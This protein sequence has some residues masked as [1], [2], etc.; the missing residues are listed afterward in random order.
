M[1]MTIFFISCLLASRAVISVARNIAQR[2]QARH[3]EICAAAHGDELRNATQA[4]RHSVF[5][6]NGEIAR[7]R[8]IS[9]RRTVPQQ[10]V[11]LF[12]QSVEL[13]AHQPRILHKLKLAAD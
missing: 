9:Y 1:T 11:A 7:D 12:R 13:C 6:W 5:P 10:R 4:A 8:A 2:P 3:E